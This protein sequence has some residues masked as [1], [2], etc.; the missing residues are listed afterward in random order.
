MTPVAPIRLAEG[1]ITIAAMNTRACAVGWHWYDG[2]ELQAFRG[3]AQ[4]FACWR[5]REVGAWSM[6]EGGTITLRFGL[7]GV[8]AFDV[9]YVHGIDSVTTE[10]ICEQVRRAARLKLR[11]WARVFGLADEPE[12]KRFKERKRRSR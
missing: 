1:D 8:G 9:D 5:G 3:V 6:E 4:E 12:R 2:P 10:F 7:G 11:Q